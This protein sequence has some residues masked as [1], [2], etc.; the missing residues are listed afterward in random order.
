V[1]D[2]PIIDALKLDNYRLGDLQVIPYDRTRVPVFGTNYIHYLY[3]QCLLSRP[4]SPY[5]VLPETFCG[6]AD[7][8]ADAICSYLANRQVILLCK[9]TSLTEFTPAGFA[10]PTEII[11]SPSANSAFAAF[12]YFKPWWGTSESVILGMLGLAYLFSQHSLRTI[13]G[14]RYTSNILAGKWMQQYGAR[15][16]GNIPDL[17]RTHDGGLVECTVSALTRADF[18]LCCR[19]K[20][21]ALAG[22]SITNGQGT[23]SRTH[24]AGPAGNGEQSIRS[25]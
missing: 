19:R 8:S 22:D 18:E 17:L 21:L 12:C 11:L 20:L 4:S 7:L 9:H 2:S 24:A 16:V 6:M 15:D 3:S 14:Q 1:S 23:A 13:L 25:G 10:W 5:G